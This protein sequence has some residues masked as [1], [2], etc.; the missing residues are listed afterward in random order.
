ASSVDVERAFSRG[1]LTVSKRRHA[2]SDESTRA[3]IVLGSWASVEGLVP[4]EKLITMFREKGKRSK[5]TNTAN[6]YVDV[7]DDASDVQPVG[8]GSSQPAISCNK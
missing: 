1:G 5:S 4:T 7:S 3:A 6:V 8:S 2:L